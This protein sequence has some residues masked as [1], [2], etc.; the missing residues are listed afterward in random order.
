MKRLL[1]AAGSGM[2]ISVVLVLT[3]IESFS[4]EY[5]LLTIGLNIMCNL[6][7]DKTGE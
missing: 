2:T 5:W 4:I 6:I 1:F 3:R 7:Y